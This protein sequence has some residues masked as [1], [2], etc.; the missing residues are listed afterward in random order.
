VPA[1]SCRCFAYAPMRGSSAPRCACKHELDDHRLGGRCVRCSCSGYAPPQRCDCGMSHAQHATCF[2]TRSQR[3][4]GGRA[5]AAVGGGRPE[6]EAATGA[7][8]DMASLLPAGDRALL[9]QQQQQRP[10]LVQPP[11]QERALLPSACAPAAPPLTL[12]I[13]GVKGPNASKVNGSYVCDGAQ[14]CGGQPLWRALGTSGAVI[15][16]MPTRRSWQVKPQS[17]CCA[18]S[19]PPAACRA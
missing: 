13:I 15:E 3:L 5:A 14:Q 11:L 18:A 17:R 7:V 12:R 2:E 6:F 16:C 19:H 8:T 4:A 1:C 9:Q 10:L